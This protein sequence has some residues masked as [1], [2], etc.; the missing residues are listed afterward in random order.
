MADE[1]AK[2]NKV[3]VALKNLRSEESIGVVGATSRNLCLDGIVVHID[4][5]K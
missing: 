5:D 4:S 2:A 1:K 3:V